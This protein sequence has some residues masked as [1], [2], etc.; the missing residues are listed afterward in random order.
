VKTVV[1]IVAALC[2]LLC[3]AGGEV[4][5]YKNI[6]AGWGLHYAGPHDEKGHTCDFTVEDCVFDIVTEAPP[7]PGSFD[8]YIVATDV[9][10]IAGISYGLECDEPFYFYSWTKCSDFEIPT[11]GW[12]GCGE[13]NAQTWASEQLGP[14]VTVGIL[15][16]YVYA[17]QNRLLAWDDPRWG[18]AEMCDGS[19][20]TP[21]CHK[22]SREGDWPDSVYFGIVGFGTDGW[23]TCFLIDPVETRTWGSIKALYR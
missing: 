9:H 14:N 7:G 22:R 18:F 4:V 13:G 12:P 10:G 8:V 21:I 19:E 6:Y 11:E 15:N 16:V 1:T 2:V 17:G 5:A 3:C 20:P 23:N